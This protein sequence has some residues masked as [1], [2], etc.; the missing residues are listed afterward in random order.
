MSRP[1]AP[2]VVNWS[3]SLDP[4]KGCGLLAQPSRWYEGQASMKPQCL[5]IFRQEMVKCNPSLPAHA[6]SLLS[7]GGRGQ[8]ATSSQCRLPGGCPRTAS[9]ARSYGSVIWA[10]CEWVLKHNKGWKLVSLSPSPE[11]TREVAGS[12]VRDVSSWG[13]VRRGRKECSRKGKPGTHLRL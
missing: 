10:V 13:K 12:R 5:H 9:G 4:Q 3:E 8:E 2:C 6:R 1:A 11:Q 7:C